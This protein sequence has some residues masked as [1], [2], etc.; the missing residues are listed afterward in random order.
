MACAVSLEE[1]GGFEFMAEVKGG[2]L[3]GVHVYRVFDSGCAAQGWV[4]ILPILPI[5]P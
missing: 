5:G 2:W 1:V 4:M 3:P